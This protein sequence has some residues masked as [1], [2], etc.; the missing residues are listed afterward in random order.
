MRE[1]DPVVQFSA[2]KM[3]RVNYSSQLVMLIREVRQLIALGYRIPNNIQEI[4]NHAKQFM[5]HA[6][7]LEQVGV[8]KTFSLQKYMGRC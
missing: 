4:S 8:L 1:T 3:M 6:K 5:T 2:S 7:I